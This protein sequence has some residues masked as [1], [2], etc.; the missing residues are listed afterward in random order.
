[1]AQKNWQDFFCFKYHRYDHRCK[2]DVDF[3]WCGCSG[4][5]DTI[6]GHQFK[7]LTEFY[8]ILGQF[9]G[10]GFCLDGYE[11]ELG[12]GN[13]VFLNSGF[14]LTVYSRVCLRNCRVFIHCIQL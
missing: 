4:F 11:L 1:M 10:L 7:N 12:L 2:L 14:K 3:K 8:A 5:S 9:L 6:L 13:L